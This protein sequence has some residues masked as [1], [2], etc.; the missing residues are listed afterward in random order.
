M[1]ATQQHMGWQQLRSWPTSVS[2]LD[3]EQAQ[4]EKS[5]LKKILA[6]FDKDFLAYA[7]RPADRSDKQ[8]LRT[9]YQR[10][11][12]LKAMLSAP[13]EAEASAGEHSSEAVG[14]ASLG[15]STT[16]AAAVAGGMGVVLGVGGAGAH[17]TLASSAAPPPPLRGIPT[18]PTIVL[19]NA[20]VSLSRDSSLTTASSTDRGLPDADAPSPESPPPPLQPRQRSNSAGERLRRAAS[21]GNLDAGSAAQQTSTSLLAGQG[22]MTA[23]TDSVHESVRYASLKAEK[24][25]LQKLLSAYETEFREKNGRRVSTSADRAPH[26]ASYSRYKVLK[27]QLAAMESNAP[28]LS[29]NATL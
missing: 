3:R 23:S 8:P 12:R 1:Q 14:S 4:Q 10:Y 13:P 19:S 20:A 18:V 24:R 7:A 25:Q 9:L 17:S 16:A 5:E 29:P 21:A 22:G 27:R 15:A 6:R 11:K 26:A 28:R 2:S